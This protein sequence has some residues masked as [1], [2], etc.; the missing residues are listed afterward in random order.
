MQD[1]TPDEERGAVVVVD[2]AR[3]RV[4]SVTSFDTGVCAFADPLVWHPD[5]TRIA[6]N[7][8]T[9]NI[10]ILKGGSRV[11]EETPDGLR[12][13]GFDMLWHDDR[14]LVD[15][16]G[17]LGGPDGLEEV[18]GALAMFRMQ[19]NE[20]TQAVVGFSGRQLRSY[21]PATGRTRFDI[22]LDID[23]SYFSCAPDGRRCVV[24]LSVP[25]RRQGRRLQPLNRL[26]VFDGDDGKM[27]A[28]LNGSLPQ[29]GSFAWAPDGRLALRSYDYRKLG[30]TWGVAADHV[31]V[32][33]E[34][35]I[36]TTIELGSARV[37]RGMS[38]P[39]EGRRMA[40]TGDGEHLA[41]LLEGG[42][43]LVADPKAGSVR[44]RFSAPPPPLPNWMKQAPRWRNY[45]E[46]QQA[47]GLIATE[48]RLVRVSQHAVTVWSLDGKRVAQWTADR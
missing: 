38:T 18:P 29:L 5:G 22:P 2:V 13:H 30:R 6:V 10:T 35:R 4:R 1:E 16:G 33:A 28:E 17:Y 3:A 26:R 31:D 41:I 21:E 46:T 14:I 11:S 25:R 43:I 48:D 15:L 36:A 39:S 9:N 12:D 47:G 24:Q 27:V 44:R 8:G 40:F 37:L 23:T 19:W 34:D 42:D 20:A 45:S 32:V 7:T